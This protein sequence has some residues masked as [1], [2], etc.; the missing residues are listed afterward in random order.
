MLPEIPD[1]W[2]VAALFQR[3]ESIWAAIED[4]I[5]AGYGKEHLLVAGDRPVLAWMLPLHRG[6]DGPRNRLAEFLAQLDCT[7][8]LTGGGGF[9]ATTAIWVG[10]RKQHYVPIIDQMIRSYLATGHGL[11]GVRSCERSR[12]EAAT[13][14]LSRH[15]ETSRHGATDPDQQRTSMATK[16]RL[17]TD[18][19][20]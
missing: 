20:H 1:E 7:R 11:L 10:G 16:R 14:I 19:L 3:P 13:E 15:S 9:V 12:I 17:S 18:R 5:A 4:L 8:P 2:F 6:D